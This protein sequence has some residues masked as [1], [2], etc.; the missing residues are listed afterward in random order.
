ML[1]ER[2]MG[3]QLKKQAL[4]SALE[5]AITG[6]DFVLQQSF[7]SSDPKRNGITRTSHYLAKHPPGRDSPAAVLEL[8]L[9][10]GADPDY[11]D[12]KP[13]WYAVKH[14]KPTFLH[15][16][17]RSGAAKVDAALQL[18]AVQAYTLGVALLAAK[19]Q[20]VDTGGVALLCAA[21]RGH[22][23][24]MQCLLRHGANGPA[25][26]RAAE[27]SGD[28]TAVENLTRLLQSRGVLYLNLGG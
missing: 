24:A 23:E 19:R 5:A 12:G 7:I 4:S 13:L 2:D 9:Q 21:V 25:A 27:Y 15:L 16:L 1:K 17:L 6:A 11:E 10:Q 20:R 26:L 8:L 14:K 28:V 18:A 22:T 3:L